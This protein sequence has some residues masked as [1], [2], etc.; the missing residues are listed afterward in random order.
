MVKDT[1]ARMIETTARL[2]QHRGYHGTSLSDILEASGAPRGSLYFHFPGGKNQLAIEATKTAVEET[3]AYLRQALADAAT[4]ARGVRAFMDAAAE[5]MRRSDYSFGCPVAPVVLDAPAELR[6]L[7]ELCRRTFERWIEMLRMSFAD[8]GIAPRRAASLALL[9]VAAI[10][11]ALLISRAW[12]DCT[13]ITELAAELEATVAAALPRDRK[14]AA[15]R[16]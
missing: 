15:R 16:R 12:R 7:D 14:K 13:P 10:E 6:E 2:L 4:P 1:S 9:T 5:L 11:G 8:A 3:T